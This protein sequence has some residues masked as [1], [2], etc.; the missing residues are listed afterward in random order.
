MKIHEIINEDDTA[1]NEQ[2]MQQIQAMDIKSQK[3]A[4]QRGRKKARDIDKRERSFR[5][6]KQSAMEEA[7]TASL[8]GKQLD[9]GGKRKRGGVIPTTTTSN[10]SRV[11]VMNVSKRVYTAAHYHVLVGGATRMPVIA[12]LL[13][14]V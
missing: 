6:Q 14:A 8:L 2:A 1:L 4:Q 5:K 12:K 13:E 7:T 3:K 10:R 9:S 11:F